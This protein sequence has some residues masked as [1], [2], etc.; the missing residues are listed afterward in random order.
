MTPSAAQQRYW[1]GDSPPEVDHLLAQAEFLGPDAAD[2]LDRIGVAPG[3]STIDIGCGVLGILPQLRARVGHSGRVVGLDI[4][5]RL[6]AV[7]DQLSARHGLAVKTVR[8][9]A[10]STGLPSGC[11]DLVHE[12]MLLLNLTS[13]HDVITE[14][15]RLAR[16]GGT[17]ALQE[18]DSAAWA[19]DPP[20]PAWDLLLTEV[21]D[22]YPRT[23]RDFHTGRRAARLLREAGL[24]D[25]QVSV[26]ARLTAPGEYFHT[27]LLTLA[28]LMREEILAA[29]RVTPGQL[30][31]NAAELREHL[32]QP[33][34]L[35]CLP[36]IWQAWGR[37]PDASQ[38]PATNRAAR[39]RPDT[40]PTLL[41]ELTGQCHADAKSG[42]LCH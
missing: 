4:E 14:M 40:D 17:L 35:T 29:S 37:K 32:S 6:L 13:P 8:A 26:L 31:S 24:Q 27:F 5:P 1:L 16:P 25:V 36:T 18:P 12:R 19:I 9:D 3:T 41:P 15:A 2:L 20:H 39:T 22:V 21:T 23:G 30:D 28:V 34:T 33:G 11:F 42:D 7:A 10:A 38:D